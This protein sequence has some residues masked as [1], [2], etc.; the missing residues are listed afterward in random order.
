MLQIAPA[1]H[2]Y[3][4]DVWVWLLPEFFQPLL[5]VH[6]CC[7]VGD[8]IN[9]KSAGY[10]AVIAIEGSKYILSLAVKLDMHTQRSL[11]GNVLDLLWEKLSDN[12]CR[13][14]A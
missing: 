7:A 9:Q 3:D 12:V 13:G 4:D 6:V 1:T 8:I 10:A 14:Y 11:D 2:K 5:D